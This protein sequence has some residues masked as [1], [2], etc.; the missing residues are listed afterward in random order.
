M[1]PPVEPL[2]PTAGLV[3][4][5]SFDW[6]YLQILMCLFGNKVIKPERRR[7]LGFEGCYRWKMNRHIY[8]QKSLK[9]SAGTPGHPGVPHIWAR[10]GLGHD[11]VW[12]RLPGALKVL[13][14]TPSLQ[15]GAPALAVCPCYPQAHLLPLVCPVTLRPV[16]HLHIL[17]LMCTLR[18]YHIDCLQPRGNIDLGPYSRLSI[19]ACWAP[20]WVAEK[21]ADNGCWQLKVS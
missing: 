14:Y 16:L 18:F 2:S 5:V 20:R 8:R 13:H 10:S 1:K 4:R 15:G 3:Y 7:F 12:F 9:A 17:G 19:K 6:R 21:I 11:V